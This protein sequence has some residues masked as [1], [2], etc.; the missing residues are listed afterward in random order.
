MTPAQ[1]EAALIMRVWRPATMGEIFEIAKGR[2]M[3]NGPELDPDGD[4][5]GHAWA[6]VDAHYSSLRDN[7]YRASALLSS[8][9]RE[10]R[11][12]GT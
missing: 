4:L 2:A 9:I 1:E 3:E 7:G 12:V 6:V 10:D 8:P 5:N 11:K